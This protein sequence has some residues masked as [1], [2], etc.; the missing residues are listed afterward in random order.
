MW[1][2]VAFSLVAVDVVSW[3]ITETVATGAMAL[4]VRPAVREALT[5][6]VV[7]VQ[8]MILVVAAEAVVDGHF[9]PVFLRASG[10]ARSG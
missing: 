5:A 10:R 4:P 2:C 3:G 8:Q 1:P 9:T 6:Q 7:G